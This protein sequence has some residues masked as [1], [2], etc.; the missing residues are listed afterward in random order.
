MITHC[1]FVKDENCSCDGVE[2][3]F[4][5]GSECKLYDGYEEPKDAFLNSQRCFADTTKCRDA[6]QIEG[7]YF[8]ENGRFRPS[9]DA[10]SKNQG[11]Y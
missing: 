10:C 5:D 4:G 7:K 6:V 3:M 8:L 1:F 9:H 2:N 11:K